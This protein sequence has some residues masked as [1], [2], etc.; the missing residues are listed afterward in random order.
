MPA[1][2]SLLSFPLS[3]SSHPLS[4]LT[5]QSTP[6]FLF[7]KWQVSHRYQQ[8]MAYQVLR[9]PNTAHVLRLGMVTQYKE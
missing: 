2:V 9:R 7:R 3:P 4:G 8:I 6:L 1:A 5:P